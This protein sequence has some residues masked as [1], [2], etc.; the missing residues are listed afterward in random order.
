MLTTG[1]YV[2]QPNP[3]STYG[4]KLAIPNAPVYTG[5]V[6]VPYTRYLELLEKERQLGRIK[7]VMK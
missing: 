5:Y 3:T 7:G 2:H 1:E 6:S 4:G